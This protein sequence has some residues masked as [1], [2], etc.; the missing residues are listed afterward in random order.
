MPRTSRNR[1]NGVYSGLATSTGDYEA[2]FLRLYQEL[3][4]SPKYAVADRPTLLAKLTALPRTY[5]GLRYA[6]VATMEKADGFLGRV[7]AFGPEHDGDGRPVLGYGFDFFYQ[8]GHFLTSFAAAGIQVSPEVRAI[9]QSYDGGRGTPEQLFQSLNNANFTITPDQVYRLFQ[10]TANGPKYEGEV[11]RIFNLPPSV[12]RAVLLSS[13]YNGLTTGPF[14]RAVKEGRFEEAYVLMAFTE[15]VRQATDERPMINMAVFGRTAAG[16]PAQLSLTSALDYVDALQRWK[17]SIDQKRAG[18]AATTDGQRFLSDFDGQMNALKAQINEVA[19][20]NGI[21]VSFTGQDSL[22]SIAAATGTRQDWLTTVYGRAPGRY[23]SVFLP[24][25]VPN[26]ITGTFTPSDT[27]SGTAHIVADVNGSFFSF[28][29]ANTERPRS[30]FIMDKFGRPVGTF[31]SGPHT[32]TFTPTHGADGSVTLHMPNGSTIRFN[33]QDG[34]DHPVTIDWT[35]AQG[36]VTHRTGH[37]R[38]RRPGNVHRHPAV[39]QERVHLSRPQRNA[40]HF[41]SAVRPRNGRARRLCGA[42]RGAFH[43]RAYRSRW[44]GHNRN[45]RSH[46]RHAN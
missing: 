4:N 37:L 17:T 19:G 29:I 26:H 41:R 42:G 2:A 27:Q 44:A 5:E 20:K 1:I 16:D 13:V 31:D 33:S 12:E 39:A 7:S 6:L 38:R 22:A 18:L 34:V 40:G 32:P 46:G 15:E 14:N 30:T 23:E 3:S 8:R 24:I 28:A 9:L 36:Q 11:N 10:I 35:N 21:F 43:R 45:V 25:T